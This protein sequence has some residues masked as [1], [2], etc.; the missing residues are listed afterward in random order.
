MR[1]L[2]IGK[3]FPPFYG[4]IETFLHDLCGAQAAAGLEVMALVHNHLP[5]AGTTEENWPVADGVVKVIRVSSWGR[6]LFTPVSPVFPLVLKKAIDEFAPD[7]L[8]LHLPNP[9]AFWVMALS[10][11]RR[12]PWVIHWHADVV[13][14]DFDW[15][16]KQAYRFY[17]PFEQALIRRSDRVI[18]TSE[19]YLATS[20]P[21]ASWHSRCMVIPLGLDPCRIQVLKPAQSRS[22]DLDWQPDRLKVLAVGRLT[23]YK[24]FEYL[25]RAIAE[26]DGVQLKI[27][28]EGEKEQEL[29]NLITDLAL[30]QRAALTGKV[31]GAELA[32][33][34]MSCD[35]LCLP[36][37]ERT[38]AFGMVLLE[39]MYCGKPAVVGDVPGSGM[40]WVVQQG[41]TGIKVPPADSQAL[42]HALAEL[43][44][45]R[46]QLAK[47]GLRAKERFTAE[48]DISPVAEQI[49]SLYHDVLDSV[50]SA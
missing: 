48:F 32:T 8:H 39:A 4:G 49:F 41:E 46:A 16:V 23:Y 21:L 36:S 34:M 2:H 28:G 35:C 10:S 9:S 1:I 6:L 31:T 47:M 33:L 30:A 13:S 11:A 3:Y 14:A 24:G 18:A 29:R 20:K 50:A 17:R 43:A 42:A 38:E 5:G 19:P 26:L 22:Q 25:L 40:G 44:E 27:V 37:V 7:L 45:D 12:I 15:R